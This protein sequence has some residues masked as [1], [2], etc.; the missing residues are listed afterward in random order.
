MI[1]K[2]K[3]SKLSWCLNC[4]EPSVKVKVYIRKRDGKKCRC[5]FCLNVGCTYKKDL[6]FPNEVPV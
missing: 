1:K 6:P 5:E 2:R 3:T 4:N